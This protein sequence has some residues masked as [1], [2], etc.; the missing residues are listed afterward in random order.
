MLDWSGG[1]GEA[2]YHDQYL[3]EMIHLDGCR[4]L[5]ALEICSSCAV[6]ESMLLY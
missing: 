4:G 6:M 2:G 5:M 3:D 1:K